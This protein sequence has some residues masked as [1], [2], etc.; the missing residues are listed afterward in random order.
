MLLCHTKL[1]E[2]LTVHHYRVDISS[3]GWTVIKKSRTHTHTHAR[4]RNG[5]FRMCACIKRPQKLLLCH[6]ESVEILPVQG[7]RTYRLLQ[8]RINLS[9]T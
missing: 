8:E 5:F 9:A 6:I 1:A 7:Y 2:F 3:R 4:A